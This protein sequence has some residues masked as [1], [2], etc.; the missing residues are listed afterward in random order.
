MPWP[1]RAGLAGPQGPDTATVSAVAC[2]GA[3]PRGAPPR[4]AR[5]PTG[6]RTG[7]GRSRP[8]WHEAWP[9]VMASTWVRVRRSRS[10]V[11]ASMTGATAIGGR[12]RFDARFFAW[13][14]AL[15]SDR[16]PCCPL[17]AHGG[18]GALTLA[19][20]GGR[21]PASVADQAVAHLGAPAQ[22]ERVPALGARVRRNDGQPPAAIG[23]RAD[24]PGVP[25]GRAAARKKAPES[26]AR[27]RPPDAGP[28]GA[29][30]WRT[31]ADGRTDRGR[32]ALRHW[33][34]LS[35]ERHRAFDGGVHD[36]AIVRRVYRDEVYPWE[37]HRTTGALDALAVEDRWSAHAV[38]PVVL[39]H[40]A[41]GLPLAGRRIHYAPVD[42]RRERQ[43]GGPVRLARH[44]ARSDTVLG[45][46]CLGTGLMEVRVRH[47][48]YR[49]VEDDLRAQGRPEAW[50]RKRFVSA[51]RPDGVG[52]R[53]PFDH[54]A[55]GRCGRGRRTGRHA[56]LARPSRG[57][58][59]PACADAGCSSAAPAGRRAP[60]TARRARARRSSRCR[61]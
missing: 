30:H 53:V 39:A 49:H 60:A 40:S 33:H 1:A 44:A 9:A 14:P 12:L 34:G 54:R 59:G 16:A 29:A 52:E 38:P 24:P 21:F 51:V 36:P 31:T 18:A 5:H 48:P 58:P 10:R 37:H 11:M 15:G 13:P 6:R 56:A 46:E 25:V 42:A 57:E 61:C 41:E 4:A 2:L 47:S 20:V 55:V 35:A 7:L 50:I 43:C 19:G 17:I 3:R 27:C 26:R 23:R 22:A 8:A 28:C 45:M 32:D